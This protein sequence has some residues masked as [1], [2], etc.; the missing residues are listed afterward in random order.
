M[1]DIERINTNDGTD[2]FFNRR[3]KQQYRS[4]FGAYQESQYVYIM[5]GLAFYHEQHEDKQEVNVFEVGFGSGLNA[6]LTLLYARE[7]KLKIYYESIDLY[8]V[9]L[10]DIQMFKLGE[11]LEDYRKYFLWLHEQPWGELRDLDE[12]F[13]LK[14]IL[15]DWTGYQM[16]GM[17]DVVY[18]DAFSYDVQPQMWTEDRFKHIFEHM[19]SGGVLTT[20]ASKGEIKRALRNV[21]FN[22]F[23]LEGAMGKRHMLR[24]VKP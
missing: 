14:K 3:F 24:A 16:N 7:N 2:T 18:Y 23:R 5:Q 20:Y 22:L 10:V 8:P 13:R 15:A 12:S 21:G 6:F 11:V 19:T 4:Y 17:F 1:G 9:D